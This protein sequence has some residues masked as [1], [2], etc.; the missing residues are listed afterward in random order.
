MCPTPRK[1]Y[2]VKV[3]FSLNMY[4]ILHLRQYTHFNVFLLSSLMHIIIF[5]YN[6]YRMFYSLSIES[7][8]KPY[9]IQKYNK[10]DTKLY[11]EKKRSFY[12][13][14]S[15]LYIYSFLLL[16]RLFHNFMYFSSLWVTYRSY[17]WKAYC[18]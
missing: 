1:C 17:M 12:I 18:I 15:N 14:Y 6:L 16:H 8:L 5:L 7:I 2:R 9:N 3:L 13:N 11:N 10:C 4:F